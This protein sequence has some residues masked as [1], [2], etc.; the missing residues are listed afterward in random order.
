MLM[1]GVQIQMLA[2]SYLTYD[3][4]SSGTILGLVNA[5]SSIPILLFSL[6]GGAIADQFNRKR[7]ILG[8]QR[9]SGFIAIV[10]AIA[11]ASAL[12]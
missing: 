7:I 12:V 11:I 4:E 2:S 6:F 5:G 1:S 8:G 9:V 3:I 10:V